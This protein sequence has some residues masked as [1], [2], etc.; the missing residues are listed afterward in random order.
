MEQHREEGSHDERTEDGQG[1]LA[2]R[3]GCTERDGIAVRGV[4]VT[5]PLLCRHSSNRAAP[6][7]IV[8]GTARMTV[9]TAMTDRGT[10]SRW[11]N[12]HNR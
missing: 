12:T 1:P 10:P 11:P 4:A 9:R 6:A 2:H 3:G 8:P 7:P 5:L